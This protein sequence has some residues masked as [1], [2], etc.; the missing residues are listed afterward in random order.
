MARF[1]AWL[2]ALTCL[3]ALAA[4]S[5]GAQTAR[6]G[7]N[8]S[9]Q[10]MQQMQQLASER[11]TLQA[12]NDK[13]KSQLA[14]IKKDRDALKTAQQGLDRRA[15][16]AAAALAH[17][18]QQRE[19]TDQE[20]T[21][22]KAKMQELIAKFRETIQKLRDVETEDHTAQQTLAT[23]DRELAAC[24][25]HNVALYQLNGEVLTHF[26][27]ESVW[28]R[29]AS[30]EPFT[31]IKRVRNENLIDGYRQRAEE[32][33]VSSGRAGT[34]AAPATSMTPATSA[35]SVTHAPPATSA[36]PATAPVKS[37]APGATAAPAPA[38]QAAPAP[39]PE[40]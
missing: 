3:V 26:E 1:P 32:Q 33:R 18:T 7:G 20:L 27:K 16:D 6:T 23:R 22:T 13:L 34:A 36:A 15:K 25:D 35:T 8:A 37:A 9:A 17:D 38:S 11:T 24:V 4:S 31:Q 40:H 21:Q 10:L 39:V 30:A 29:M 12:E 5:A 28:S 19:A 2:V 14:D